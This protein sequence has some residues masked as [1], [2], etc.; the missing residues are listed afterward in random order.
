M[1]QAVEV[2]ERLVSFYQ[3]TRRQ[4]PEGGHRQAYIL[5][6]ALKNMYMFFGDLLR[7]II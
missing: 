3:T 5:L 4:N 1:I 2:S 6:A 7:Y